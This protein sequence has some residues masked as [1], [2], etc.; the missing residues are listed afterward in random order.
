MVLQISALL[1]L[2]L[3]AAV[4][5]C[6]DDHAHDHGLRKRAYPQVPLT[7]P[8]RPLQWGDIN[9][10]ALLPVYLP[11]YVP[12]PPPVSTFQSIITSENPLP[13]YMV[14]TT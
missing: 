9:I 7:A 2:L 8:T 1:P 4:R 13:S 3:A 14:L 5:A 10:S 11:L 12:F 6:G